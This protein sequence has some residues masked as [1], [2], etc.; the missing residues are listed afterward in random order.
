MTY[1]E[2]INLGFVRKNYKDNVVY[3]ETG[4]HPFDLRKDLTSKVYIYVNSEELDKPRLVVK[5]D[6]FSSFSQRIDPNSVKYLW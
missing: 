3:N 5:M 2:Y 6:D 4:H 1:Q